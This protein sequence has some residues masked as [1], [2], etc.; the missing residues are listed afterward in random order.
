[1]TMIADHLTA[2]SM[3]MW[4]LSL[5]SVLH[6]RWPLERLCYVV[7]LESKVLFNLKGDFCVFCYD[8][9]KISF[10]F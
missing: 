7:S 1:M 9:F 5:N 8:I 10:D 4:G 2:L 3:T 6:L